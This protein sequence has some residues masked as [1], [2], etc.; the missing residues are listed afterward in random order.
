VESQP[1]GVELSYNASSQH[2]NM[3]N[4]AGTRFHVGLDDTEMTFDS[5]LRIL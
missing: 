1:T 5:H 3:N 2:L 4:G